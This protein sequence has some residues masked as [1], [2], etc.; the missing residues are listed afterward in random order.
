MSLLLILEIFFS[1]GFKYF[2]IKHHKKH[3]LS[4]KFLIITSFF[5]LKNNSGIL[6][7]S[8]ESPGANNWHSYIL[9]SNLVFCIVFIS[10]A[11]Y[12][13]SPSEIKL[14]FSKSMVPSNN[15]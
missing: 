4:F 9:I 8:N 10:L 2:L 14:M 11:S 3:L 6:L 15:C 12:S 13:I 5:F 7:I 1:I